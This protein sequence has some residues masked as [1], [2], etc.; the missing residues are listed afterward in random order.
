[1]QKPYDWTYTTTHPGTTSIS[2]TPPRPVPQP[3][4]FVPAP[5][6]HPGIPLHLL[7]RQDIPILFYDEIPLFEDELGDN[8]IAELVVRVVSSEL[9]NL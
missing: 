4:V 9:K 3:P 5:S 2:G 6:D 1:M 7:A 8:G